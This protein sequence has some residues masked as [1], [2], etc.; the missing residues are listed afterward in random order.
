M[1]NV[2]DGTLFN[3]QFCVGAPQNCCDRSGKITYAIL[4]RGRSKRRSDMEGKMTILVLSCGTRNKLIR[5]FSENAGGSARRRQSDRG[6]LQ[7][8]G[9]RAV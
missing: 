6:G 8:L 3:R 1:K 7:S 2:P 9:A 5:F 4:P